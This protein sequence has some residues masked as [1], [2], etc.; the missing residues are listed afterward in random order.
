MARSW[1]NWG[2]TVA[3]I[4]GCVLLYATPLVAERLLGDL[5][6]DGDVDF[7]DFLGLS[8]NFG[9]SDGDVFDVNAVGGSMDTVF[10]CVDT[11]LPVPDV[12]VPSLAAIDPSTAFIKN[13]DSDPED[14]GWPV[15]VWLRD[16][17]GGLQSVDTALTLRVDYALYV[18]VVAEDD[19]DYYP[20]SAVVDT[21]RGSKQVVLE[22]FSSS[23]PFTVSL[24][25]VQLGLERARP[26]VE[27]WISDNL[28]PR[29]PTSANPFRPAILN[30]DGRAR[31]TGQITLVTA[32]NSY[33]GFTEFWF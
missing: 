14:D 30:D 10:V 11:E 23:I 15:R 4:C 20:A 6:G 9:R 22:R 33:S 26:A 3:L 28:P 13:L 27:A 32:S 18:Q 2:K 12:D 8:R 29:D 5:D 16:S 24:E 19:V 25:E 21:V 17:V 7:K 31:F 1:K